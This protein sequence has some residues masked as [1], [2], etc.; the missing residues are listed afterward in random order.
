M[1]STMRLMLFF[2]GRYPR[3]AWP[4]LAEYIRPNEYPRNSNS[5]SGTLQIRVFIFVH[6]Q[7]QL[8]HD[9]AQVV[10]RLL[11]VAPWAQDHKIVRINDEASAEALLQAELLPPQ[12]KPAHVQIRQQG[13]SGEPCG[14]RRRL[15]RASVVRL[16]RPRWSVSSTG[17]NAGEKMHRR[18]GV[19]MHYGGLPARR[20]LSSSISEPA[21]PSRPGDRWPRRAA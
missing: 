19:K 18:A 11:G 8:A 21:F 1:V 9:L 5:P 2:D 20:Q 16:L 12:H 10:Q 17:V 15:S 6:C 4:V 7:L 14:M 13:E 3:R